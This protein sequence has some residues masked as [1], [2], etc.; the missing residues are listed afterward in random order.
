VITDE[1]AERALDYIRD[2]AG[3]YAEAKAQTRQLDHY[4]KIKRS[5]LFLKASG[6]VAERE[7]IAE[8]SPEYKE[9]IDGIAASE[10]EENRLKWMLLAAQ[11]KLNVWRTMSANERGATR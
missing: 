4:R 2:N 9:L 10:E 7:A 5:E 3:K 11:E 1:M 8:T 6:T